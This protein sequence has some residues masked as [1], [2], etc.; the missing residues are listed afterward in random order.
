MKKSDEQLLCDVGK[1]D[2]K[3]FREL[4]ELYSPCIYRLIRRMLAHRPADVEEVFQE[5][6]V[7]VWKNAAL[8]DPGRGKAKSWI[9][10]VASR[11]CLNWLES[12]NAR[13]QQNE[14][15]IHDSIPDH[16]QPSPEEAACRSSESQRALQLLA[17]LPDEMRQVITLR[18]LED[19]SIDEIAEITQTPSGTVKSRIF[20]GLK[21]LRSFFFKEN[22][23]EQKT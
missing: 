7:R 4:Y 17:C 6:M 13:N 18:H 15:A 8:F 20:Y 2:K 22:S 11:H 10:L 19:L 12:K 16:K 9:Y 1:G 5:A 14:S 23:H 3:A 21:K